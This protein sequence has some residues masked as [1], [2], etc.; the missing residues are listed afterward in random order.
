M[1]LDQANF[2]TCM[3]PLR[4][5]KRGGISFVLLLLLLGQA[6]LQACVRCTP[7]LRCS[8]HRLLKSHA[9]AT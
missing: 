3:A 8:R 1:L 4:L 5:V 7:I 9:Q 6:I 2:I